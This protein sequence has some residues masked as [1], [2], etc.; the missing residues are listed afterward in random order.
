MYVLWKFQ[1]EGKKETEKILEEIVTSQIP[2]LMRDI[3]INIQ[4]A[5]Q[6]SNKRS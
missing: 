2:N 4:G 3:N 6:T 5:Q 1:K